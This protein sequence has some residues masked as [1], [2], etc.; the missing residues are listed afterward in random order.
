MSGGSG[1]A[2]AQVVLVRLPATTD[3]ITPMIIPTNDFPNAPP[4][5][6]GDV[7]LGAA[8]D[9]AARR[10]ALDP[11]LLAAKLLLGRAM[12]AAGTSPDQAGA[13]GMVSV[14]IV[15]TAEWNQIACRAWCDV[16]RGG[17][18]WE[19]GDQAYFGGAKTWLVWVSDEELRPAIARHANELV[20]KAV[21]QARHCAGFSPDAAWLPSDLD[22]A[23][24]YRLTLPNLTGGDVGDLAAE[25]C[26][27]G[28]TACLSD[29]YAAT[30]TPRL[31]R[32]A[33]RPNQ[34]PAAYIAKLAELLNRERPREPP[35]PTAGNPP[36]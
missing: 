24:D 2:C 20:G 30:L 23:A 11:A 28:P 9:V 29:D 34:G 14:I 33:R 8:D 18:R 3:Y 7:D 22:Y 19:D 31:L 1:S 13:D 15:P 10:H 16:A 4:Y 17:Q 32:L 25:L 27:R 5:A 26:G 12:A 21:F 36:G 35:A 6:A